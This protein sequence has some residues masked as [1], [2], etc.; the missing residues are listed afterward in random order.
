[1]EL[2]DAGTS[3]NGI[4]KYST[5]GAMLAGAAAVATVLNAQNTTITDLD[6]LNYALTLEHL[7]ATFYTQGLKQFSSA[8]VANA[9]AAQNIGNATGQFGDAYPGDLFA[10]LLLI[11]D[12]EQTHVRTLISVINSLGGKPVLPCTYNFGYNNADDF[13]NI[14]MVLENTGVMA[15][16]GA[17]KLIKDA[18]L[19]TAA[20]T[21]ATVEARHASY[22]NF[23]NGSDPFP[24]AFDTPKDMTAILNA[25]AAT[26]FITSCPSGQ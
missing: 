15:Y 7:E 13:L 1:M 2:N 19:R 23:V 9:K 22:L 21:I 6:V 25:V 5:T 24:S 11:R 4:S 8:D 12:H 14:A 26:K 20:A 10:Y 16:D 17:A 18:K 3:E